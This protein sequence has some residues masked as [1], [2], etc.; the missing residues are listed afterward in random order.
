MNEERVFSK[1][2]TINQQ[3]EPLLDSEAYPGLPQSSSKVVKS[4][5]ESFSPSITLKRKPDESVNLYFAG[6]T[7]NGAPILHQ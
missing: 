4:L 5:G 3:Q 1:E 7:R 2:A 6:H